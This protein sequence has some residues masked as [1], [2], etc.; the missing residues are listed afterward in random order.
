MWLLLQLPHTTI[1]NVVK[2]TNLF[3]CLKAW[4]DKGGQMNHRQAAHRCPNRSVRSHVC[5]YLHT[6]Y[7]NFGGF[8][9]TYACMALL[10]GSTHLL[11]IN[12]CFFSSSSFHRSFREEGGDGRKM[13]VESRRRRLVI[14]I[15]SCDVV[16]L[17]RQFRWRRTISIWNSAAATALVSL[18]LRSK[19]TQISING[20]C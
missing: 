14:A 9:A 19:I 15:S 3:T 13:G 2:S 4:L 7:E 6:T 1:V 5:V 16:F 17:W 10:Y 12:S 8:N 11:V 20:L 18:I